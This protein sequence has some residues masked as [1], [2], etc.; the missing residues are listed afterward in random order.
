MWCTNALWLGVEQ[1]FSLFY[2]F[3]SIA[4]LISGSMMCSCMIVPSL[5]QDLRLVILHFLIC[6]SI[7]LAA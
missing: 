6:T 5:F 4:S 3:G 7:Q 1:A 2:S